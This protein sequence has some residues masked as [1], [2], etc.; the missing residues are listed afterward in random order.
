MKNNYLKNIVLLLLTAIL[1]IGFMSCEQKKDIS[2]EKFTVTF[3]ANGG[4]VSNK[5]IHTTSVEKGN[6]VYPPYAE[7]PEY[8][9]E[10]WYKD[11]ALK[12]KWNDSDTVTADITLYA[13]WVLIDTGSLTKPVSIKYN[14]L[15]SWLNT[16]ASETKINY[17]KVTEI[18]ED[19]LKKSAWSSS[20]LSELGEKIQNSNKKIYLTPVLKN[21]AL[22]KIEESA[23]LSLKNLVGIKLPKSLKI[24]GKNA[25][26]GC[27]GLTSIDL[28]EGLSKIEENAFENCTGLT[29]ISF[30][31]SLIELEARVFNGCK[32]LTN[33]DFSN[34][35][36]LETIGVQAFFYCEKFTNLDLSNCTKLTLIE[37]SAFDNC[38]LLENINL[39]TSLNKIESYAFSACNLKD[40]DLSTCTGLKEM[41]EK[42]YSPLTYPWAKIFG[43]ENINLKL[44]SNITKIGSRAFNGWKH[45]KS[46]DIPTSITSIGNEAFQ[47]CTNLDEIDLSN[48]TTLYSIG[49]KAFAGCTNATIILPNAD[50]NITVNSYSFGSQLGSVYENGGYVQKL[51]WVKEVKVP[52]TDTYNLRGK[53]SASCT[54]QYP[55]AQIKP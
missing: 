55:S 6:T 36:K 47:C 2:V 4:K 16:K 15:N 19:A 21:G 22:S 3:D 9:F 35:T 38:K 25:F 33:V 1:S 20:L 27:S 5:P 30:P 41:V 7:R 8:S 23:F 31:A 40:I 37:Q 26:T 10:G 51:T 18:P 28:P 44:P 53:V 13:K 54:P 24:I 48:N 17:I 43:G 52:A 11:K 50:L 45:L 34:C 42:N 29:S 46:I 12:T 39:P 32:G 14:D 49:N